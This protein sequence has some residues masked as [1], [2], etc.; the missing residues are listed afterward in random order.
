[1]WVATGGGGVARY[2]PVTERFRVFRSGARRGGLPSDFVRA[3]FVD[4][5]GRIWMGTEAGLS[6]YAPRAK[7]FRTFRHVLVP[8]SVSLAATGGSV[9]VSDA[10]RDA[11]HAIT[12]QPK[13]TRR[14]NRTSINILIR[15]VLATP[16]NF[17]NRQSILS[18][19][20]QLHS[21]RIPIRREFLIG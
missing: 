6:L 14:I 1:M 20:F 17:P 19:S 13:A 7:R 10:R 8:D 5:S 12:H 3:A 4:R 9:G 16:A 11:I 18:R 21:N 15:P 2:D